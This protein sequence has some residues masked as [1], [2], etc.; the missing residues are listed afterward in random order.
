MRNLTAADLGLD[1]L[2]L[3][4]LILGIPPVSGSALV[5][6]AIDEPTYRGHVSNASGLPGSGSSRRTE[7]AAISTDV[8]PQQIRHHE[9]NEE[10][11]SDGPDPYDAQIESEMEK[12]GT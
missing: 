8:Q 4:K 3:S 12:E 5:E 2:S 7:G 6:R 10:Q 9:F 11:Q 1:T